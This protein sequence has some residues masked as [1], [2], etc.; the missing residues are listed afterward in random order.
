MCPKRLVQ[1]YIATVYSFTKL[2]QTYRTNIVVENLFLKIAM[3]KA[4][5]WYKAS[6]CFFLALGKGQKTKIE[7]LVQRMMGVGQM[8]EDLTGRLHDI[9]LTHSVLWFLNPLFYRRF[10][11]QE[12]KSSEG[13]AKLNLFFLHRG[14]RNKLLEKSRIFRYG[15]KDKKPQ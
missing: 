8:S 6:H 9:L 3:W 7:G 5:D 15:Q 14:I 12:H 10:S 13:L 2:D 11:D 4:W 1:C